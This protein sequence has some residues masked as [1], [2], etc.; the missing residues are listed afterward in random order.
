[1]HDFTLLGNY[2]EVMETIIQSCPRVTQLVLNKVRLDGAMFNKFS[3]MAARLTT[4]S[5]T[6]CWPVRESDATTHDGSWI[7][8]PEL[9]ELKVVGP[10]KNIPF[11]E[12]LGLFEKS[13]KLEALAWEL[14][15]KGPEW[16]VQFVRALCD[17]LQYRDKVEVG[18]DTRISTG[19]CW[20]RLDSLKITDR[21]DLNRSMFSQDLLKELLES[22]PNSLRRFVSKN[23]RFGREG[24]PA[25]Q[26]H[27][28]TLE[29]LHLAT[30]GWTIQEIMAS[31]PKLQEIKSGTIFAGD[32]ADTVQAEAW[33]RYAA[34]GRTRELNYEINTAKCMGKKDLVDKLKAYKVYWPE[35]SSPPRPWVC[36]GLRSFRVTMERMKDDDEANRQVFGRF[37]QLRK[38]EVINI[39]P[40]WAGQLGGFDTRKYP[41]YLGYVKI[42]RSF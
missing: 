39:R 26:R 15:D 33:R 9:R 16:T 27:L 12:Q 10:P 21:V 36:R 2:L 3:K 5:L 19:C 38:L 23:S 20:P 22:C 18:A 25:L 32:V 34:D 11:R 13:S 1:M 40:G 29:V 6:Y 35:P 24:W 4:L 42:Q 28:P 30:S 7:P 37:A 41:S 17:K 14:V 8:F 31:C